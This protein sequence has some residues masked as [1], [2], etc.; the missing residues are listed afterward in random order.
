MHSG[1]KAVVGPLIIRPKLLYPAII[2]AAGEVFVGGA[3]SEV[4]D[5]GLLRPGGG[6]SW[7]AWVSCTCLESDMHAQSWV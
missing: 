6:A 4:T 5:E 3:D 2:G 1:S 7:A